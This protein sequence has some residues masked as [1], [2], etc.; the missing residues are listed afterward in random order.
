[1][2]CVRV[3]R[4]RR[5]EATRSPSELDEARTLGRQGNARESR[6]AVSSATMARP[7][8]GWAQAWSLCTPMGT[9]ADGGIGFLSPCVGA[10]RT[11]V[12]QT[13]FVAQVNC[14]SVTAPARSIPWRL[15]F[16]ARLSQLTNRLTVS[17]YRQLG[18][19]RWELG[20]VDLPPK[21]AQGS[22]EW[23]LNASHRLPFARTSDEPSCAQARAG[24]GSPRGSRASGGGAR[25]P[26]A[27]FAS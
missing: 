20:G 23:A 22:T 2:R 18:R 6:S 14:P 11:Y 25:D 26:L 16:L 27:F 13:C 10:V 15:D 5:Q 7:T 12:P 19:I 3:R 9:G 1:M 24:P 4:G 8:E 21:A 17:C